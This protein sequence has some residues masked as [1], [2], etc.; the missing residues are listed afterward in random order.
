MST[1]GTEQEEEAL[2]PPT[3]IF[4]RRHPENGSEGAGTETDEQQQQEEGIASTPH[5]ASDQVPFSS[6]SN[7]FVARV[8]RSRRHARRFIDVSYLS[9]SEEDDTPARP[10]RASRR[11]EAQDV[12]RLRER[13][14]R[15]G[16]TN[17]QETLR[18][19]EQ[20]GLQNTTEL[21][22]GPHIPPTRIIS[23]SDWD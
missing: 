7:A 15:C 21:D 13:L 20:P 9:P 2:E 6:V 17:Q 11:Q 23:S 10:S 5:P 16:P 4:Y 8:D 19:S 22:D 1:R 14:R 12:A 3:R 18:G